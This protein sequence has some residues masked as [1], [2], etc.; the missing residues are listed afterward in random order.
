MPSNITQIPAPRA[1]V[2]DEKTGLISREWY[3]FFVNLFDLTGEG[4]NTTSLTDL[5]VGPPSLDGFAFNTTSYADLAPPVIPALPAGSTTQIQYNN[6]GVFGGS[7]NF[8]Y[9]S[10][11]NTVSFGN[12]TGSATSMT[13]QPLAPTSGSAGTLT[14][15]GRNGVATNGA[16]GGLTFT[17]GN[18]T[19]TGNGGAINAVGGNGNAGGGVQF[20]GGNGTGTGIGGAVGL[21]GGSSI[22]NAGGTAALFG[23]QSTNNNGGFLRFEGGTAVTYGQANAYMSLTGS[24]GNGQGGTVSFFAGDAGTGSGANAG[25]FLFQAGVG[26]TFSFP[27]N[28]GSLIFNSAVGTTF[29]ISSDGAGTSQIGFFGVTAI[30]QPTVSGSRATGA[31]L[32]DLLTKLANL[33]L[34]IDSTTI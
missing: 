10:G 20:N 2:I 15:L 14:L 16:G 1:P 28:D 34:I 32:Q 33:G 29:K 5:Q 3:R 23:G 25:S 9:V 8:T 26:D 17:S 7:A 6:A 30:A 19:G 21:Q 12:L 24:Y 4:S 31:A 13:I 27:V 11:T 18:G 22:N